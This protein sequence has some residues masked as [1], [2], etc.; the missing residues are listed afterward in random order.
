MDEVLLMLLDHQNAEVLYSVC[1]VLTNIAADC[2]HKSVLG[3]MDGVQ[4]MIRVIARSSTTDGESHS[5]VSLCLA[6]TVSHS[7]VLS[8]IVG[9]G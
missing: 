7:I 2:K 8:L 5:V 3:A 4:R 6:L 1:G 9:S